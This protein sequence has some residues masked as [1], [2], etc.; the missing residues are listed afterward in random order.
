MKKKGKEIQT[1][2]KKV[3]GTFQLAKPSINIFI[4]SA[5]RDSRREDL[6]EL[7]TRCK[8]LVCRSTNLTKFRLTN[9]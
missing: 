4:R 3:F 5:F 7:L 9:R 8:H 6:F 2:E 1:G